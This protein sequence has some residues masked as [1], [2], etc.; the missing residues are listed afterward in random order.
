MKELP[1]GRA[2][3]PGPGHRAGSGK[4]LAS[5]A[6]ALGARER[7]GRTTATPHTSHQPG[8]LLLWLLGLTL[9]TVSSDC[10]GRM[11]H[12]VKEAELQ[13]LRRQIAALSE[14]LKQARST[15]S[16]V[17][18]ELRITETSIGGIANELRDIGRRLAAVQEQLARLRREKEQLATKLA[19][20]RQT[21]AKQ[22]R[23]AYITG[24]Q[25]YLKL[26]LNQE[27]PAALERMLTYYRYFSRARAEQIQRV[28][29]ELLRL[30]TVQREISR[31]QELLRS[32]Q[33][34]ARERK[35]AQEAQRQ[36]RAL[37]LK[38][39][40]KEIRQ[41]GHELDGLKANEKELER[42]L[43][44][45]REAFEDIPRALDRRKSFS[46]RRGQLPWPAQGKLRHRFGTSRNRGGLKWQGVLIN[47][48]M[49]RP[50]AAIHHGRIAF[51][52]WL[53]GFGLLIIIDHGNGYMSLYGHNQSLL[54]E[55]GDWVETGDSVATV[56]DSGGLASSGLYF[57]I[58]RFGIPQNP[59]RWCSSG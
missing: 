5:P 7:R 22:V 52:D 53:R 1:G 13:S 17:Q 30:E 25:D 35:T 34:R 9:L 48:P 57:E 26:L 21:L 31:Q 42:L 20:H 23:A 44:A 32:L 51:A 59:S 55:T 37:I 40:Q 6:A 16:A 33:A 49:G 28:E 41:G 36:E 47:A 43:K 45:L 10:L 11:S 54:K 15:E 24:N 58:R 3:A 12:E 50:V 56:G 29:A 18:S 4:L 46:Q 2:Q 39:L 14:H 8:R 19:A 27:D 38:R